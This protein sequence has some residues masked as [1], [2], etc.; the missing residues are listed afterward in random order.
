M[1][2]YVTTPLCDLMK[3]KIL[4]TIADRA[5]AVILIVGFFAGMYFFFSLSREGPPDFVIKD[6]R[7][8]VRSGRFFD[9]FL[10]HFTVANNGSSNATDV[11]ALVNSR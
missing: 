2:I 6:V 8:E 10:L 5:L 7:A 11:F 4:S 9:Q 1:A 3:K